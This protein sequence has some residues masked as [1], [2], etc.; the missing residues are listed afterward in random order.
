MS[1]PW[2]RVGVGD[3]VFIKD[4]GD[5]VGAVRD[6][7]RRA[8]EIV[9]NIENAGDFVVPAAAVR[10]VHSQKVI[11]DLAKLDAQTRAALRHAH[12]AEEPGL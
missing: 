5:E 1:E 10:A 11:L 6:V 4:G 9:I 7:R 3:Q 2:V 12:D 8:R